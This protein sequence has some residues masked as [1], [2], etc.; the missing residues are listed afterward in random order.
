MLVLPPCVYWQIDNREI[1]NQQRI[2]N[3][4]SLITN[5]LPLLSS[6]ELFERPRPILTQE[7]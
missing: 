4:R 6:F 7:A 3:Q 2:N 1:N 5:V